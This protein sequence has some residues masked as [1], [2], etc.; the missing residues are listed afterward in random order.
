M[1]HFTVTSHPQVK[2]L[3]KPHN[4]YEIAADYR[5]FRWGTALVGIS[6]NPNSSH[7][8]FMTHCFP[9]FSSLFSPPS[10]R[11]LSSHLRSLSRTN[12]FVHR[13]TMGI[14][15]STPIRRS[16]PSS[17]SQILP[18]SSLSRQTSY[19]RGISRSSLAFVK[20]RKIA[21]DSQR[22]FAPKRTDVLR[23]IYDDSA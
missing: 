20:T 8:P 23:S 12:V 10:S 15:C 5:R 9:D 6:P 1:T 14:D 7:P 13:Q 17:R 22:D 19:L 11:S 2:N 3:S 16:S 18:R 4:R 21:Y